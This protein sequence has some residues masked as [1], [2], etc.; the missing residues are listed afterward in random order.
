MD[1]NVYAS[2][3]VYLHFTLSDNEL[4]NSLEEFCITPMATVN[5]IAKVLTPAPEMSI[6]TFSYRQTVLLYHKS[7]AWLDMHD[8]SSCDRNRQ[9]LRLTDNRPLNLTQTRKSNVYVLTSAI[10]FATSTFSIASFIA[11]QHL[12]KLFFMNF[13]NIYSHQ[14]F[15]SWRSLK[16]E[17]SCEQ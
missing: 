11:Y 13:L 6:N 9:T 10:N 16:V 7:L 15:F 17:I 1:F 4:L 2:S 12:R 3:S 5:S 14:N 8:T